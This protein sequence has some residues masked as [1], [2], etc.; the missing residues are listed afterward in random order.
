MLRKIENQ[1]DVIEIVNLDMMIPK[2]HLLRKIDKAIDFTYIYEITQDL[3]CHDNGRP[4]IDPVILIKMVL[5]QHIYGIVSLRRTVA[6]IQMN[7]A[8]RWFLGIPLNQKIPHFATVSY[9]FKNRFTEETIEKI[10]CWILKEVERAG[11]LS[12]E[13][14]FVD[15]THIKA[16]AALKKVVKKQIP[17]AAKS[18]EKQLW[19]EINEDRKK[20]GKKPFDKNNS[21]EGMKTVRQSVTDEESGIFQKGENKRCFAYSAHTVC[22]K[23]NFILDSVITAGN[24]HDSRAFDELYQRTIEKYPEISIVTADAGYKTPWICKQIFDSGRSASM[25]Y[26]RP[27]TKKGN[28]KKYEYVY[29]EYYDCVICPENKIL[30]YATTNREGYKEYKSKGY[31]CENCPSKEK[32]ICSKNNQKTVAIHIWNDYIE[33]AEDIR[34]SPIGKESYQLRSQTIERVFAD[35]KEKHGMRYTLYRGLAQVSKWVRLKYAAMNLKKLA[36]WRAKSPYH[37][38]IFLF[39]SIFNHKEPT[40]QY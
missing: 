15:A 2:D 34:Y 11:Y 37:F 36:I 13:V 24:V 39:Y 8:Y 1:R 29:D 17:K 28:Y 27:M 33:K 23:H 3:Y 6:E 31:Q 5:I 32:C 7:I 12:P 20:H 40:F 38:I 16:N 25:P 19:E 26:K 9:N 10:F 35:A 21:G 18:Y 22:D 4:A 30:S 14:V